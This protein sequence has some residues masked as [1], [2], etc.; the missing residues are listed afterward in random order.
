MNLSAN[1]DPML[2]KVYNIQCMDR[3][4]I[5]YSVKKAYGSGKVM[6]YQIHEGVYVVHSDYY[7][8]QIKH[9][10]GVRFKADV[11]SM[12][13]MYDGTNVSKINDDKSVIV[14]SG[15]MVNF[16]GNSA[17]Y[18][19]DGYGNHIV[20]IGVFGYSQ[21]VSEM[22]A[23]F[24]GCD[25]LVRDYDAFMKVHG[26][27]LI[28]RNDLQ[29]ALIFNELLEAVRCKNRVL[30]KL[31]A[32]ELMVHEMTHYKLH[33]L[34]KHKIY[35]HYYIEKIYEIKA[36]MDENWSKKTNIEDLAKT[37]KINKTYLK[38]IF[39]ACFGISPHQYVINLRLEKSKTLLMNKSLKIEEIASMTGFSSAGRYSES[40]KKNFGYLPSKFRQQN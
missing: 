4:L 8:K 38:E 26:S 1:S 35:D 34:E 13:S 28:C 36:F 16:A 33:V 17:F 27:F 39:K 21:S 15:D 12:Y 2:Q 14:K 22:F 30:M 7:I 18:E 40:F 19:S 9:L 11:I 5:V 10:E 24:F 3:D 29:Y 20:S 32:L 31:K 37:Y 23:C 25:H 6:Y